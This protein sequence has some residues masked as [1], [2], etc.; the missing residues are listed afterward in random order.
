MDDDGY[1]Y[2]TDRIKDMIV[3][4][5]ENVSSSEVESAIAAHPAVAQVAVVAAPDP[6]WGERIHAFIELRE[7]AFASEAEIAGHCRADRRLQMPEEHDHRNRTVAAEQRRQDQE[8][9]P[10]RT[11]AGSG[12]HRGRV[13]AM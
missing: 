7:G 2:I 1:L 13:T 11:I 9:C 3:T 10:A 4:G 12:C 8:R 5:G 6:L